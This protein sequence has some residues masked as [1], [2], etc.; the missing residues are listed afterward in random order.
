MSSAEAA[1]LKLLVDLIE[2][3]FGLSFEGSRS[4]ILKSRLRSRLQDLQLKSIHEYY[5]YLRLHPDREVEFTRL[6]SL[7]TNNETYFFREAHQFDI[8]VRHVL[9]PL[10][11]ALKARPFKILCAGCSSGEEAYSI[12]IA[13]QNAGLAGL[14][15]EIDA[16]DM[17]PDR[18]ARARSAIYEESSL[19]TC[20]RPVRQRY[21]HEVT[22]GYQLKER[23][24]KGVR[25]FGTNLV[26][27]TSTLGSGLY[28]A[29]LCRNMLIYFGEEAI[30]GLIAL[31][32]RL[33]RRGGY[34]LLGHAE[35]LID[36]HTPFVAVS[37][38]GGVIYRKAPA[39]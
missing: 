27:G 24:R 13:L 1:D 28:D 9:P 31:F 38:E 32:A 33:L 7:I 5:L 19:R 6:T 12:V 15:W 22:G 14:T 16:H 29:I 8:L 21:F 26:A 37:V 4:D 18:I 11:P 23:H 10:M 3:K 35:S 39:D 25:F 34:L 17:N 20:D 36:R 2:A 30:N